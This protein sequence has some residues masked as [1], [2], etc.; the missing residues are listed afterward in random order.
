MNENEY[1]EKTKSLISQRV[2]TQVNPEIREKQSYFR[3]LNNLE[4]SIRNSKINHNQL[5]DVDDDQK[6][7]ETPINVQQKFDKNIPN[8]DEI[9]VQNVIKYAWSENRQKWEESYMFVKLATLPFDRGSLRCS[10][11]CLDVM[12]MVPIF[13]HPFVDK[14]NVM[15]FLGALISNLILFLSTK[16]LNSLSFLMAQLLNCVKSIHIN[17]LLNIIIFCYEF[18]RCNFCLV[19]QIPLDLEKYTHLLNQMIQIYGII[20]KHYGHGA[21]LDLEQIGL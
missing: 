4:S 8:W 3:L 21:Q 19:E 16:Q 7:I 11:Y 9:D 15:S 12:F 1:K 20:H 5:G 18:F 2:G 14:Y 17:H 13:E 6:V 10:Y